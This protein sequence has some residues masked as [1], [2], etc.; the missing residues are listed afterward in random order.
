MPGWGTGATLALQTPLLG[1]RHTVSDSTLPPP[2]KS[3][4]RRIRALVGLRLLEAIRDQ[5]V[6]GE[7]L[8]EEDPSVTLPRRLG[9]S[10]VVER[11]IRTYKEDVRRGTR[12]SDEEVRDLFRLVIR[13]P[14]AEEIFLQVGR[15]LA[16]PARLGGWRRFLPK[17]V[18]YAL[19]RSRARRTLKGL[20]GRRIGGFGRGPCSV[21]GRTLIFYEADPG[22][23]ACEFLTGFLESILEQASGRRARVRHTRCQARDDAHCRWEATS[24]DRA[25][26]AAS[27][28]SPADGNPAGAQG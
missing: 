5:D 22:G 26:Q 27:S 7:V 16:G 4:A 24:E 23:E 9:L 6:P 15:L 3:G 19:A 21:E 1:L 18:A 14:D 17:P 13:R 25:A 2:Q 10:E 8:E 12:L 11:Q 28:P 20:F